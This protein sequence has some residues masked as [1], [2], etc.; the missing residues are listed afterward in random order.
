[1]TDITPDH[2]YAAIVAELERA[3]LTEQVTDEGKPA[4]RH[5]AEGKQVAQKVAL[6][7]PTPIPTMST[8]G[9]SRRTLRLRLPDARHKACTYPP[10]GLFRLRRN[11]DREA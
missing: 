1:M 8:S 10:A 2:E 6:S 7:G 5:T 3:G 11:D 4:L 9:V